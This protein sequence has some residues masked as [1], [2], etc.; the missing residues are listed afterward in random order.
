MLPLYISAPGRVGIIGNPTDMYGGSVLSCSSQERALVTIDDAA[1]LTLVAG[2]QELHVH[3]RDDLTL[4]RDLF[5]IP[6]A[7]LGHLH[8]YDAPIRLSIS[9]EIPFQAGMSGSAALVVSILLALWTYRGEQ[10]TTY[11]LAEVA[12]SIELNRMQNVCGYQDFY[13]CAFG[14]INYMDFRDKQFYR[15]VSLEHY[16][17][18]ER[19]DAFVPGLPFVCAKKGVRAASGV[20]HKPIRERWLEGDKDV[21][22]AYL[23][24]G[25]LAREGKK[26]L[27]LADWPRLGQLMNENHRIQ[28]QLGGSGPDNEMM[29]E[30]ALEGGAL[31]AKLAGAGNGGTTIAL[32]LEPERLAQHLTAA[33]A[34]RIIRPQPTPGARV[35]PSELGNERMQNRIAS[36]AGM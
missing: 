34:E 20:V 30:A 31:G 15:E 21:V 9:S 6:K 17:T 36:S 18:V 25:A 32:H 27:L 19:L 24:I 29:I 11:H 35:E 1:T 16:G 8:I 28:R 33:G 7:V 22:D 5:D 23:R 3:G 4:K 14:G 12:R 26:A 2:G 10:H 13:M